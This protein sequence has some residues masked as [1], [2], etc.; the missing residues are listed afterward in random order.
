MIYGAA[1]AVSGTLHLG[2]R[3]LELA[4]LTPSDALAAGC[5]LIPAD[6]QESGAVTT[7]SVTDNVNLPVLG[8]V[9]RAWALVS[10]ALAE[11]AAMLADRFDVRPRDPRV[12]L[13]ALSGGNQQKVLLAK[14]F[15]TSPRL[16][17]LDEPTQGVDVGARAQVFSAIGKVAEEG[18]TVLCAS[19][20]YE[21][22]AAI[23]D[24][25]L[26]FSR[27]VIVSELSGDRISKSAIAEAC[28]RS[29]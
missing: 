15:Q 26:V 13:G 14:W 28:Y 21:Q 17:L 3:T 11:N 10:S 23:C 9:S 4:D 22:L 6:R 16:V 20:D 7:L 24:R 2:G 27:G 18:A 1:A 25:V 29:A 12:L 8:R 5:I 19:S